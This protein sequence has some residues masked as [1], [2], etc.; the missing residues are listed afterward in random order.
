MFLT[1]RNTTLYTPPQRPNM[2]DAFLNNEA[3][4]EHALDFV[5][6]KENALQSAMGLSRWDG[7][8]HNAVS[9]LVKGLESG[10][11]IPDKVNF[12]QEGSYMDKYMVDLKKKGKIL[13][14]LYDEKKG[15]EREDGML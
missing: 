4:K 9:E 2:M 11:W 15:W 5:K 10:G 8:A 3:N 6:N 14:G 7:I 13:D 12:F 1:T